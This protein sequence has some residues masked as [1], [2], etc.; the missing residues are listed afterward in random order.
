MPYDGWVLLAILHC[1]FDTPCGLARKVEWE[2]QG[3]SLFHITPQQAPRSSVREFPPDVVVIEVGDR[4]DVAF[5]AVR[6]ILGVPRRRGDRW[7]LVL[8]EV[9]DEDRATAA[10]V[11]PIATLLAPGATPGAVLAACFDQIERNRQDW[12]SGAMTAEA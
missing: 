4:A 3:H 10:K 6:Q 11:A 8:A 12:E 1:T 9:K 7:P 2:R 5:P